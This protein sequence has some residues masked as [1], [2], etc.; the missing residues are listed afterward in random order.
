MRHPLLTFGLVSAASAVAF[1]AINF[2]LGAMIGPIFVVG[3]LAYITGESPEPGVDATDFAIMLIGLVLGSQV[4][5]EVL[6]HAEKWPASILLLLLTMILILFTLGRINQQLL[7]MKRVSAYLAGAPGN[8]AT[9]V[10]IAH[11]LDGSISQVAIYHS[12]RLAFLTVI[13]PLIFYVP[14]TP[15][16]TLQ[17]FGSS[18]FVIWILLLAVAW[19]MTQVLKKLRV[20]TPGLLAGTIVTASINLSEIELI[21]PPSFFISIAMIIFG[22]QVAIDVLKQGLLILSK[23]I[24]PAVCLNILGVI[25]A[26]IGAY[27]THVT[28]DLPL[29]DTLLGFMPGGFQVMPVVAL[30]TGADGLYV[31]THHLIRVLAMGMLIPLFAYYWRRS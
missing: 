11:Q 10:A 24:A 15:P 12:L 19:L 30:E 17:A 5:P 1:E 31:T 3:I 21:N 4:T 7:G 14:E 8:L 2:P 29:S 25:L 28:I 23:T 22:W 6:N 20:T 26:A 18:D 16:T 13:T 27:I 9:A